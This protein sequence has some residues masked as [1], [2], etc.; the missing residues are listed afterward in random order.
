MKTIFTIILFSIIVVCKGQNYTF[1]N[2]P[3]E[4]YYKIVGT[5][6]IDLS[7]SYPDGRYKYF[8]SIDSQR[9][10]YIFQLK[11]NNVSGSFYEEYLHKTTYG[12]YLNDS[13]WSFIK[14]P[15][16]TSFKVGT[17]LT[18]FCFFSS[19]TGLY[20]NCS[21]FIEMYQIPY[22]SNNQ[23]IEQWFV[24][25]GQLAREAIFIKDFGLL[26]ETLWDNK[27]RKIYKNVINTGNDNF[28]QSITYI[29]DSIAYCEFRQNGI[30]TQID[31]KT[32][33]NLDKHVDIALYND[34]SDHEVG[35]MIINESNSVVFYRSN[36]QI[37]INDVD[38][39]VYLRYLNK[40]G[41]L[42]FKRLRI[43]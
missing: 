31:F 17:W 33:S 10:R 26:K 36:G 18:K 25:D 6:S 38:G 11:D 22:D 34:D 7:K 19:Y 16:D 12:T 9:P 23:F 14:N 5:D 13:V 37:F 42:K 29:N 1:I 41:K 4:I 15:N 27:T 28:Y 2:E 24:Y 32:K 43:R 30:T 20:S 8:E 39:K 35:R 3:N 40:R 21:S